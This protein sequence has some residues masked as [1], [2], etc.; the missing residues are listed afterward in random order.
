[1]NCSPSSGSW[2]ARRSPR[3]TIDRKKA[4]ERDLGALQSTW[5]GI[6]DESCS[7]S[8][9]CASQNAG[10]RIRSRCEQPPRTDDFVSAELFAATKRWGRWGDSDDRGAINLLT[11]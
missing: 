11:P 3:S 2:S 1:M 7:H 5:T 6:T 10:V 9:Q 8:A 4:V